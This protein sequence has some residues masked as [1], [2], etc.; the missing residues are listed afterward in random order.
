MKKWLLRIGAVV[1]GIVILLAVWAFWNV[2][3]RHPGY[4]VDL[5]IQGAAAPGTLRVGFAA[6]PIT[7]EVVDT[8][9]DVNGDAKYRE[10]DGD[11]YNDNNDNGKFDPIWIAGFSN[12]RAANGVHDD[13]WARVVVFDDGQTRLALVSLDAIG[14]RHDEVVDIRKQIPE[15]AGLD[16]V[17]ISSTH[18]HESND[19][20]GIWG[21]HPFKSGVNQDNLRYVKSQV[22]EALSQAISNLRSANLHM[23]QDLTGAEAMVQDTR[24]PVVMDAGLRLIQAVDSETKAT[25]GTLVAWGNHP[26]TLWSDNLYISSDFPHYLRECIEEGVYDGE[27]LVQPGLGGVAVYLTGAIGGLMT[28]RASMPLEDPFLD[29]TYTEASFDKAKAQGTRL[30]MLALTALENPDTVVEH[31]NL[32]VRAKTITLPLEN[33]MFRLASLLGVLDFGMTGWFKTRSEIAAFELGP[34]SFICVPGEIYPEIVNGGVEAP[35]GQDFQMSPVEDPALRA[36]MPGTY[37]FVV[38]LANDEIGYILPKSQ[39]DVE[40]PF[41]YNRTDAPYGEENSLGP[42]TASILYKE[43][44]KIL[45]EL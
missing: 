40:A 41:T 8:W 20:I 35:E 26:E 37:R 9:N 36:L 39:W 23:A 10:E 43:F 13:V 6:L 11:T 38:G 3:D 30:A 1:L 32:S 42:E 31:A 7:P 29:T 4:E 2:R 21:E 18:T 44:E 15:E 45:N 12:Q 17:V 16:Y 25:L 24:D 27:K 33:N 5:N 28:T 22:L 34:A 19:L 14:F